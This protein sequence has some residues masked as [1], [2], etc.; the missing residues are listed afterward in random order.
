MKLL[1]N[2]NYES[3]VNQSQQPT[4]PKE[5]K[6]EIE[7]NSFCKPDCIYRNKSYTNG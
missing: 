5:E 7:K 3:G 4:P 6:Q 2:T 1:T